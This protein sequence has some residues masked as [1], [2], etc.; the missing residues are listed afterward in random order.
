MTRIAR[1][2]SLFGE[3]ITALDGADRADQRNLEEWTA[4]ITEGR[5]PPLPRVPLE[6]VVNTSV[7]G[8][9]EIRRTIGLLNR[10]GRR[11]D[12]NGNNMAVSRKIDPELQADAERAFARSL[13]QAPS[14]GNTSCAF[15][16]ATS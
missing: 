9:D 1:S 7:H 13:Q 14:N 4:L 15:S 10:E 2:R 5:K 16:G 11:V 6:V 3:A 8:E 12:R